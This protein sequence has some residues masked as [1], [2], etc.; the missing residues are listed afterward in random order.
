MIRE[1]P[2]DNNR[3]AL[4]AEVG[5]TV[6][7]LE[8][9]LELVRAELAAAEKEMEEARLGGKDVVAYEMRI[10]TLRVAERDL[11]SSLDIAKQVRDEW[12]KVSKRPQ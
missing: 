11:D 12:L 5:H 3:L 10:E 1:T 2:R 4:D 6:E 9:R 7:V 8:E